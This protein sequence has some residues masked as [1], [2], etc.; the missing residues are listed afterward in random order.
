MC[1]GW[2]GAERRRCESAARRRGGRERKKVM[3]R[4]EGDC[5]NQ[6]TYCADVS[7]VCQK[8]E[9]YVEMQ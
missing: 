9:E 8:R 1:D 7:S 4:M 5:V 3:K 6:G 2:D